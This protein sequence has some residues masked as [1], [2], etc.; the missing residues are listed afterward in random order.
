MKKYNVL[1]Q[2]VAEGF[3]GGSSVT[4]TEKVD[5]DP[6]KMAYVA[7]ELAADL[8]SL[9]TAISSIDSAVTKITSGLG[10]GDIQTAVN[11]TYGKYKTDIDG[12]LTACNSI[13]TNL[14]NIIANNTNT[15]NKIKEALSALDFG[16]SNGEGA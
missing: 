5:F 7:D 14:D 15:S 9:S 6:D 10:E 8:T 12:G 2:E 13:K 1:F 16:D 4:L 3:A 11:N